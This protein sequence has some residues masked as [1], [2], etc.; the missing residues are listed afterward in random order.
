MSN[1][2]R[3]HSISQQ[4]TFIPAD[5]NYTAWTLNLSGPYFVLDRIKKA[6]VVKTVLLFDLFVCATTTLNYA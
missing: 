1:M 4:R 5:S 2:Y 3:S 6:Y